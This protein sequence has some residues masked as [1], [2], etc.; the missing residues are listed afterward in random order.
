[1]VVDL[2]DLPEQFVK[3]HAGPVAEVAGELIVDSVGKDD[4]GLSSLTSSH[5][6]DDA[7]LHGIVEG[8]T[9]SRSNSPDGASRLLAIVGEILDQV[10]LRV[11][12]GHRNSVVG[13]DFPGEVDGRFP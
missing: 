2:L 5:V 1:M 7:R 8:G 9:T 12:G 11:E 10:G 6:V 13:F 3:G 4:D